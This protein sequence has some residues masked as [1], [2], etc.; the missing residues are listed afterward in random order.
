MLGDIQRRRENLGAR[1]A[2]KDMENC[3]EDTVSIFEAVL[4]ALMRRY[5]R[6]GGE[7]EEEIDEHF[8]KIGNAFQNVSRSI[9]IFDKNVGLPLFDGQPEQN[10]ARLSQIFE[11]RHPITHNLGVVDKKYLEK[12]RTAEEEGKVVLVSVDEIQYAIDALLSVFKSLYARMFF[13]GSME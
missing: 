12:V 10:I 5:K 6:K 1:V 2:A 3:L 9:D 13:S 4:R 8:R 11:K 7:S